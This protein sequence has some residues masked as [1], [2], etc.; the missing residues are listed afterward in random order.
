MRLTIRGHAFSDCMGYTEDKFAAFY[1]EHLVEV[2][3][4][5][6]RDGEWGGFYIVVTAPC[7]CRDYDGYWREDTA[8]DAAI[9]EALAGSKLIDRD[10]PAPAPAHTDDASGGT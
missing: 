10:G 5:P 6:D 4:Q 1:G 2:E 7:G 8:L 3:R 9:V